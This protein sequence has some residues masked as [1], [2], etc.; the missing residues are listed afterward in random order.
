MLVERGPVTKSPKART[1]QHMAKKS[2]RLLPEH[3][4]ESLTTGSTHRTEEIS[5]APLPFIYQE[6]L[7][8]PKTLSA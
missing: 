3:V 2:L 7:S 5:P 6:N 8:V 1:Q 4:A